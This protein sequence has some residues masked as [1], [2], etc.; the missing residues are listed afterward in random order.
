MSK[1]TRSMERDEVFPMLPFEK[2]FVTD[3]LGMVFG[4]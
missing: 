1:L 3:L 4:G 2:A